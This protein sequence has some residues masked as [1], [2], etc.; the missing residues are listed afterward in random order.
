MS[1]P[2]H[3]THA[4][5]F[6]CLWFLS[7]ALLYWIIKTAVRSGVEQATYRLTASV[8]EIEKDVHELKMEITGKESR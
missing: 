5:P 1:D 3:T 4:L 7:A 6:L 2:F 8:R